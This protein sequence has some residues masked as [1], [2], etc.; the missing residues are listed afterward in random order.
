MSTAFAPFLFLAVLPVAFAQAATVS[1]QAGA[2]VIAP[3]SVMRSLAD[4]PVTVVVSGGWVRLVLPSAA[5]PPVSSLSAAGSA[6]DSAVEVPAAGGT[7]L[8]GGATGADVHGEF[9]TSLSSP[10]PMSGGS[11]RVTVAFN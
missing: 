9:A 11:Y 8:Q 6:V 1:A 2:T 5:P 3:A 4:L 10:A 7:G